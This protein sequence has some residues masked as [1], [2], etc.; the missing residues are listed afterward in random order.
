[1]FEEKKAKREP[2]LSQEGILTELHNSASCYAGLSLETQLR[3][4]RHITDSATYLHSK[5]DISSKVHDD[6]IECVAHLRPTNLPERDYRPSDPTAKVITLEEAREET[7][8]KEAERFV[9]RFDSLT[10]GVK[11]GDVAPEDF[12]GWVHTLLHL[13]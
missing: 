2:F 11:R 4:L 5:G 7:R 1:M 6:I 9:R 10:E 13:E 8:Q 12:V 3:I